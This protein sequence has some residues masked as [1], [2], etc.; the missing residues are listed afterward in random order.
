[1]EVYLVDT[2]Y[3]LFENYSYEIICKE[4]QNK[5]RAE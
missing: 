1:M 5:K 3:L 4:L 2:K